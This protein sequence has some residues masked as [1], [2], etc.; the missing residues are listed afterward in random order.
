[1][2]ITGIR[3]KNI[4]HLFLAPCFILVSVFQ[5]LFVVIKIRPAVVLG[6]GGF[7]SGPGGIAA[8]LM[9]IPLLIHEQ[10][11][12]AG[13]TNRLLSPFAT[14]VMTAFP[15]VFKSSKYLALFQY[16]CNS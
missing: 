2:N 10:N 5:A 11:S 16:Q 13:L 3:G 12:I 7:V 14:S 6:M 15:D 9:R 8:W 1:M 4:F